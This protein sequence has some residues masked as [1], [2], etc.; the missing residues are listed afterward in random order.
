M[1]TK[2]I[3]E[4][5][6][7]HQGSFDI[8]KQMIIDAAELDVWGVKFQKRDINSIPDEIK[9]TKRNS[10]NSFGE[11]YGEHRAAL[12]LSVKQ[13]KALKDFAESMGLSFGVSVF[14]VA[15]AKQML[16]INI[17]WLKLPS[18]LYSNYEMNYFIYN[19]QQNKSFNFFVSTGMHTAEEVIDYNYFGFQN[20]L[21]YCRSI[22][23]CALDDINF[24]NFIK[25]KKALDAK[26]RQTIM[27]YSSHDD[28]GVAIPYAVLL[29]AEYIERHYTLDKKM[30]GSD[31]KTVSSNFAEIIKIKQKIKKV[32]TILGNED[33]LSE[34]EQRVKK[35]YRSTY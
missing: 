7:N 3:L 17:P 5:G 29:G 24:I 21:F 10:H 4:V 27:G 26:K 23:P 13:I 34:S 11:T 32:E 30:K 18:Q 20:V 25:I 28:K 6:C 31:H 8:A 22:Y 14:D 19:E 15:S 35:I 33:M 9:K 16:G 12:E 2:I 1:K